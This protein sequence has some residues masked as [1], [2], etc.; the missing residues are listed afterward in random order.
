[1]SKLSSTSIHRRAHQLLPT[2]PTFDWALMPPLTSRGCDGSYHFPHCAM[3][4]SRRAFAHFLLDLGPELE[5]VADL[6]VG[7]LR[8]P[9]LSRADHG[10]ESDCFGVAAWEFRDD[11]ER[12]QLLVVNPYEVISLCDPIAASHNY[13]EDSLIVPR[14]RISRVRFREKHLE[15]VSNGARLALPVAPALREAAA[16]LFA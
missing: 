16:R 13:G 6:G 8:Q 14:H 1:M 2:P 9:C 12:G 5:Q 15:L 4:L 10:P 3:L 11:I 7:K